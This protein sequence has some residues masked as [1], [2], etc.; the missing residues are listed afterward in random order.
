MT[1]NNIFDIFMISFFLGILIYAVFIAPRHKY[2][3]TVCLG[4]DKI[5]FNIT[6][7]DRDSVASFELPLNFKIDGEN[8]VPEYARPDYVDCSNAGNRTVIC[9]FIKSTNKTCKELYIKK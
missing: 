1:R 9:N 5:L 3:S 2:D 4:E 6:I 7:N 8:M